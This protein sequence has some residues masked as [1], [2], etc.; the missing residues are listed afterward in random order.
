LSRKF[1]LKELEGNNFVVIVENDIKIVEAEYQ[2]LDGQIKQK[3]EQRIS[4]KPYFQRKGN[5]VTLMM[6]NPEQKAVTVRILDAAGNNLVAPIESRDLVIK[7]I[8]DFSHPKREA[9]IEI[10]AARYFQKTFRF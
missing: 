2:L 7:K 4:Y 6:M 3:G 1:E 9:S 8:F 10:Q 5:Q